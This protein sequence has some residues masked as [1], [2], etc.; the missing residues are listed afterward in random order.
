MFI[1]IFLLAIKKN[2]HRKF[3]K[4]VVDEARDINVK[5]ETKDIVKHAKDVYSNLAHLLAQA[6]GFSFEEFRHDT[7]GILLPDG[8]WTGVI[9]M[10]N[11]SEVDIAA[12]PLFI[13]QD[14][15]QAAHYSYPFIVSEITFVTKK[16]ELIPNMFGIFYV[17]DKPVWITFITSMVVIMFLNYVASGKK[18]GC[19]KIIVDVLGTWLKQPSTIKPRTLPGKILAI[20]WLISSTFLS[21]CYIS[22]LLSFLS[23]PDLRGIRTILELAKAVEKGSYQCSTLAGSNTAHLLSTSGSNLMKLIGDN[24]QK[25]P[26]GYTNIDNFINSSK[27]NVVYIDT[28]SAINVLRENY[29]VSNDNFFQIFGAIAA[30]KNFC[31]KYELDKAIRVISESGLYQKLSNDNNFVTV[32][33]HLPFNNSEIQFPRQLTVHDIGGALIILIIGYFIS[34]LVLLFELFI[35]DWY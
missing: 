9:G 31:C 35:S 22:V 11:R 6:M 30:R 29:L 7:G 27:N 20:S 23:F 12:L 32:L 24:I 25:N 4:V 19:A 1:K 2:M 33:S 14:R 10:L 8:N 26:N 17:F 3:F 16:P 18:Y 21:M 28:R 34:F 15:S 5:N 13:S